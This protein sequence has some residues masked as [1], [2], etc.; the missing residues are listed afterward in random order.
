M[1]NAISKAAAQGNVC[2]REREISSCALLLIVELAV[3]SGG[4]AGFQ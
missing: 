1:G 4:F 2:W 3:F